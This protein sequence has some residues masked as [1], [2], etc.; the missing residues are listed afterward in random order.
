MLI[1]LYI[2][3]II[4]MC[5]N[6]A[7][8]YVLMNSINANKQVKLMNDIIEYTD[9]LRRNGKFIVRDKE[10][11]SLPYLMH[12]AIGNNEPILILDIDNK[13]YENQ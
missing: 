1:V 10:C 8:V 6:V 11:K 5:A 9:N 12:V 13:N 7:C 2:I 4:I 3:S